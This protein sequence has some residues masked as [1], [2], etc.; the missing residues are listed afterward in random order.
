MCRRAFFPAALLNLLQLGSPLASAATNEKPVPEPPSQAEA[1]SQPSSRS[2]HT[3]AVCEEARR[4]YDA[5]DKRA[6]LEKLEQCY[7]VNSSPNVAYNI[8][9]VSLELDD[10][11]RALTYF[12]LY[13]Q[14][15]PDAER[16]GEVNKEIDQLSEQ[17]PPPSRNEKSEQPAPAAPANPAPAPTPTPLL[18]EPT[19]SSHDWRTIGWIAVGAGAFAGA[20]SLYFTAL[21]IEANHDTQQ[22]PIT[23]EYF[24]EREGALKRDSSYGIAF[25]ITG[26]VALGLG[27]YAVLASSTPASSKA[28]TLTT[29]LSPNSALLGCRLQF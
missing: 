21:A 15:A 8:A 13:A 27:T 3:A 28:A 25:G 22:R 17:C 5:H 2:D 11:V 9:V 14:N 7:V 12:Q 16:L 18:L 29:S 23:A 19:D 1:S 26:V 10:C 20:T 6:A 4:R 24:N